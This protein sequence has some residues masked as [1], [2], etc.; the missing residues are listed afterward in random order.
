MLRMYRGT[1]VCT[2]L[3]KASGR[4][5]SSQLIHPKQIDRKDNLQLI[6]LSKDQRAENYWE[7]T[8]KRVKE[9]G[10]TVPVIIGLREPGRGSQE[11]SMAFSRNMQATTTDPVHFTIS[12]Q[13]APTG[14]GRNWYWKFTSSFLPVQRTYSFDFETLAWGETSVYTPI[15][16]QCDPQKDH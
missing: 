9:H 15:Y 7:K 2:A 13:A 4:P 14:A 6:H 11:G 16:T 10:A 1:T 5:Q 3:L 8:Q 12:S